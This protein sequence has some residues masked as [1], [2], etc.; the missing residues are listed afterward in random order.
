[1]TS[2]RHTPGPDAAAAFSLGITTVATVSLASLGTL[3]WLGVLAVFEA[4]LV[5]VL[6]LPVALLVVAC[7]LSVWLGYDKDATDVVLS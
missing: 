6:G 5:A 3:I 4:A 2:L 1:M 7:L